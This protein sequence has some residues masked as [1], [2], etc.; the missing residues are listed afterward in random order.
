LGGTLTGRREVLHQRRERGMQG[1]GV[2]VGAFTAS[3]GGNVLT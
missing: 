3:T 2:G 1:I